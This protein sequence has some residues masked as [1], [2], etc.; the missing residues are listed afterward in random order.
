[1]ILSLQAAEI[2]ASITYAAEIRAGKSALIHA[3]GHILATLAGYKW[4]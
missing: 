3:I 1:V 2:G 4:E